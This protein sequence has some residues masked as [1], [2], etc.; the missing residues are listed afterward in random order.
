MSDEQRH[1][2]TVITP[3]PQLDK[4]KKEKHAYVVF[5]SGPLVGK[6]HLLEEG[7]IKL[8]RAAEASIPINDLGISRNHLQIDVKG[9]KV[10]IKDLGST[11]GTFLNGLKIDEAELKD[12]DKIQISSSTIIKFAYQDKVENIFHAELYRMAVVDALTGAY[13]KRYFE[14]RLREEFTYCLRNNVSL[15]LL[16]LDI[17]H[18]KLIND[19]CGHQAGDFI[20][21]HVATLSKSIIRNEDILARYGGEEFAVILKGADAREAMTIAERIRRIIDEST[22]EF[23]DKKIHV[24]ASIG[25]AT[26]AQKN[27]VDYE[28]MIK[29]ADQFLYQSKF[30]GRNRVSA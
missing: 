21:S 24:T 22:F 15:S 18:F 16:M 10:R 28:T 12:G 25:I 11:N 27:F 23:D 5:L 20:L 6:I 7:S 2:E 14:E 29:N 9:G 19:G 3:I 17:D 1:D 8:G 30:N 26:L 4:E 13:N